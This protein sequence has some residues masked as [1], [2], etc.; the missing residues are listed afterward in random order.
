M[1]QSDIEK[2]LGRPLTPTESANFKSNLNAAKAHLE[3]LICTSLS[4]EAGERIYETRDGYSTVFVD[5]F[6]EEPTVT[7]DGEVATDY[8]TRFFDNRNSNL[9]NSLVFEDAFDDAKEVTIDADW[10]FNPLPDDLGNL[11]AQ[12]FV[13]AAKPYKAN[14]DVK[15]KKVEDFTIAFGERSDVEILVQAN[16]LTIQKYSLCSVGN[17]RSGKVCRYGF[18]RI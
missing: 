17:I 2:W 4:C 9:K 16:A 15:S 1:K 6:T 14:G 3:D 18:D 8:S 13:I 11:L 12:L 10:G 7:I 5:Y